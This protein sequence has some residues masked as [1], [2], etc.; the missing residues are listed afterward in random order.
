MGTKRKKAK[1][2]KIHGHTFKPISEEAINIMDGQNHKLPRE[3]HPSHVIPAH[4]TKASLM[5]KARSI[6]WRALPQTNHSSGVIAKYTTD[7]EL[8]KSARSVKYKT[9]HE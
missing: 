7:E 9:P 3:R 1:T 5:K 2:I 6:K 8:M 4:T